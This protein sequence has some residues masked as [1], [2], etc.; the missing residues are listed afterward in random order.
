MENEK[1]E[2][3]NQCPRHC[4]RTSLSC[5]RGRAYFG[6]ENGGAAAGSGGG[7]HG[8]HGA[9]GGHGHHGH[10]QTGGHGGPGI[11]IDSAQPLVRALVLCGRVAEHKS[12][13]MR[14]HGREESEM[15]AA[16]T[17]EEQAELQKL[18][19]KLSGRWEEEHLRHHR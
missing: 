8:S 14:E 10:E 9:S 6:V 19:D 17:A 7:H 3:C 15:F 11:H 4:P 12:E 18:L 16:L 1:M 5:G 2:Y 13:K